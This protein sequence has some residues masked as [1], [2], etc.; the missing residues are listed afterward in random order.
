MREH[1]ANCDRCACSRGW[2]CTL[3]YVCMLAPCAYLWLPAFCIERA[4]HLKMCRR[5]VACQRCA[6]RLY[7]SERCACCS[8]LTNVRHCRHTAPTV[9]PIQESISF[10]E[11]PHVDKRDLVNVDGQGEARGNRVQLRAAATTCHI[12]L[13]LSLYLS[14]SLA[15]D[16]SLSFSLAR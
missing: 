4:E 1:C 12:V 5:T 2:V 16:R 11:M 7:T 6:N 10:P 14:H 9:A 8:S 15:L 13:S 3:A